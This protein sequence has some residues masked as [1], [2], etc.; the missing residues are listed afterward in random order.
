MGRFGQNLCWSA[1]VISLNTLL[2]RLMMRQHS[3][4]YVQRRQA[5]GQLPTPIGF[6]SWN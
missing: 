6:D 2:R 1:P 4:P 3:Q 5:E